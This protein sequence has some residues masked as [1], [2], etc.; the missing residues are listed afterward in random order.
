MPVIFVSGIHGV[1]KSTFCEL[2]T[3]DFNIPH[4]SASDLIRSYKSNLI[5]DGTKLVK[6]V[7][8][9]Q[10]AFSHAVHEQLNKSQVLII[11]GH[12]TLLT[13]ENAITKIGQNTFEGI[14]IVLILVLLE[15]PHVIHNRLFRRDGHC[16]SIAMLRKHQTLE[17]QHAKAIATVIGIPI[18]IAKSTSTEGIREIIA[19]LTRKHTKELT[20]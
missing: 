12:F 15:N 13:S 4:F 7:E 18:L 10:K 20:A 8:E 1:G 16:P 17:L 19:D 6:N 9:N 5:Q 14:S 2:I 11:D 3:H